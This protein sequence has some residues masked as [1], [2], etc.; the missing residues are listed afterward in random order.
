M[1]YFTSDLHFF[2]KR[3]Q[4]IGDREFES[5]IQ[6]NEFI[7]AQW[8][9][10]VSDE[11]EVYMLGD[12]SDGPA[13]DTEKLLMQLKG[14]KYLIVGNNDKYLKEENFN[15]KLFVWIKDYYELLEKDNKFVLFHFPIEVRSGYGK[16]RIH[17]HG[18]M[19]SKNAINKEVRRYDVGVDAHKG[20]PVSIEYIYESIGKY[21]N[22]LKW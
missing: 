12:I 21:H 13:K 14:K 9:S 1:I 20:K 11:D 6:R 18:H 22:D 16:D 4:V 3:N 19:H 2:C 8:N 15:R 17:L 10:I 5:V 7:I